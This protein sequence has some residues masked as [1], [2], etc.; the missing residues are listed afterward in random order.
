MKTGWLNEKIRLN[1]VYKSTPKLPS[2]PKLDLYNKDDNSSVKFYNHQ[3][4]LKHST[5][6]SRQATHEYTNKLDKLTNQVLK[7]NTELKQKLLEKIKEKTA[8]DE[9]KNYVN[10]LEE[11]V[12]RYR[13]LFQRSQTILDEMK[14]AYTQGGI[15]ISKTLKKLKTIDIGHSKIIDRLREFCKSPDIMKLSLII[16]PDLTQICELIDVNPSYYGLDV[17]GTAEGWISHLL[18]EL[19]GKVM[20]PSIRDIYR[21]KEEINRTGS[22]GKK[23]LED[24]NRGEHFSRSDSKSSEVNLTKK[25]S[26]LVNKIGKQLVKQVSV[27]LRNKKDGETVDLLEVGKDP[28]SSK[29]NIPVNPESFKKSSKNIRN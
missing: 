21:S 27:F 17:N 1:H 5:L 7:E 19:K 25:S 22:N 29:M 13:C 4:S 12:T 9:L 2:F 26:I 24:T 8:F 20:A 11:K 16:K 23:N 14:K 18:K 3:T 6:Q 10:K 28:K 15:L